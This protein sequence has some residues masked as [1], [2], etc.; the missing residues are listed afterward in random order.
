MNIVETKNLVKKYKTLTAVKGINL[1]VKHG[2]I[3]GLLG[4]M[5]LEKLQL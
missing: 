4:Q 1:H 2:E 5:A 3:F